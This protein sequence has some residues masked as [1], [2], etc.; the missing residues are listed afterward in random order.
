MK[1]EQG[2]LFDQFSL[3]ERVV[4]AGNRQQAIQ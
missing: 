2:E 3:D 4:L 1:V